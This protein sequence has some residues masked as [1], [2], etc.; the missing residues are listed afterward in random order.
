MR[1]SLFWI[2]VNAGPR[3]QGAA[4]TQ[5]DRH[6]SLWGFTTKTFFGRLVVQAAA[7]PGRASDWQ[8]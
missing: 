8:G 5:L 7:S 2:E 1:T 3:F 4:L 6:S